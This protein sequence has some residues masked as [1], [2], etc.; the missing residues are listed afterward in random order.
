MLGK[1]SDIKTVHVKKSCS[2]EDL[3]LCIN[4]ELELIKGDVISITVYPEQETAL[5]I[6]KAASQ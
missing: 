1:A 3:G 6:Y 4:A 5:I 2:Y